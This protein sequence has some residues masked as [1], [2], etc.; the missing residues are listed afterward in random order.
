MFVFIDTEKFI[1]RSNL[2]HNFKYDYSKAVYKTHKD[3]VIIIC[4]VHGEF[5]QNSRTHMRGAGCM[6]CGRE[7]RI[8]KATLTTEFFISKSNKVHNNKYDY[9]LTTYIQNKIK[10]KILCKEHGIFE[11]IPFTHLEGHG[12]PKCNPAAGW[13]RTEW[14]EFCNKKSKIP[15]LYIIRCFD[16]KEEFIKIGITTK[17]IHKRFIT[18][19]LPYSYEVIKEIKGSPDFIFDKEHNLH[20]LYKN[21]SYKPLKV[22]HGETECFNISILSNFQ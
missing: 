22:F 17:S 3:N 19:K 13:S 2:A 11:Q 6:K 20:R 1:E 7:S 12:C 5:I 21:S 4:S 9:S 10:V 18:N 8:K 16:E 15:T 14:I